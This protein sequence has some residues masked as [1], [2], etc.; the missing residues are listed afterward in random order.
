MNGPKNG[1]SDLNYVR[2]CDIFALRSMTALSAH[3]NQVRNAHNSSIRRGQIP[4][5]SREAACNATATM[6]AIRR[7]ISSLLNAAI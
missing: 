3:L 2:R 6:V 5:R 1:A 4:I 7:L